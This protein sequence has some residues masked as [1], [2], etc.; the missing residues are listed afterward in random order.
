[1]PVSAGRGEGGALRGAEGADAVHGLV[2]RLWESCGRAADGWVCL[3][4]LG[5]VESGDGAGRLMVLSGQAEEI[6]SSDNQGDS[7]GGS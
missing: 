4:R 6:E 5:K 3:S 1:M 2:K 7:L